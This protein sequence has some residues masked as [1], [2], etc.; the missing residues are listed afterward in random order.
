MQISRRRG[1][2]VKFPRGAFAVGLTLFLVLSVAG[3]AS[4][5]WTAPSPLSSTVTAGALTV[6]QG[7]YAGLNATYNSST[8]SV[9][10]AI[11]I[12][13]TGNV[14]ADS[15]TMQVIAKNGTA[16]SNATI[17]TVWDVKS[18]VNCTKDVGI[19]G[20]SRS[21]TLTAGVSTTGALAVGATPIYCLRTTVAAGYTSN[22]SVSEPVISLN[23]N[24]GSWSGA[25]ATT[26]ALQTY[27]DTVAPSAPGK[28]LASAVGAAQ[29]T[30]TWTGATDNVAVAYYAIY[31]DGVLVGTVTSPT[32]TFTDTGLVR[33]A[34]YSY[35]VTARDA[36]GNASAASTASS[37]TT[38]L[39]DDKARYQVVDSNSGLC[40][41]A[42]TAPA[43]SY[44]PLVI[45]GCAADRSQSWQFV[46]VGNFFR[47][48]P[49]ASPSFSWDL[50]ST[51][52]NP[53]KDGLTVWLSTSSATDSQLWQ[54]VAD[55]TG[56]GKLQFV[57]KASA[58]CLDAQNAQ[59][60]NGTPLQQSKCKKNAAQSFTLTQLP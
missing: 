4:A 34:N 3:I 38:S 46:A 52:G 50:D 1:S 11:T 37:I 8:L 33:G 29:A 36:A 56:G 14:K 12:S 41:D 22:G 2:R 27:Q 26:T 21:A 47:I 57:N 28:P 7:G 54:V 18:A 30:L 25:S 58:K 31:R 39:V 51:N 23:Y 16:L 44:T 10:A 17:L 9:T 40:V 45:W 24:T 42:G 48:V 15:F 32:L 59:M 6:A 60:A 53:N 19:P 49:A 55:S 20:G 43:A 5:L 35:T 13:N